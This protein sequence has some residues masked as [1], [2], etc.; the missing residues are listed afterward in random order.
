[1]LKRILSLVLAMLF[2]VACFAGCSN[3]EDDGTPTLVW[4]VPGDAQPRLADVIEE[5][6]KI[7]VEKIGAKV[8]LRFIDTSSY[9][10]RM[11][12]NMAS[13]D[14]YDLCFTGY[15]NKYV[16]AVNNEALYCISDILDKAPALKESIPDYVWEGASVNGKIY[17]V[18]NQQIFAS[19][20]C[21]VMLKEYVDKYGFDISKVT[22]TEDIEPFLEVIKNNEPQ[23]YPYRTNYGLSGFRSMDDKPFWGDVQ[24]FYYAYENE[25]G[26]VTYDKKLSEERALKNSRIL[27][28]WYKKGYIRKDVATVANDN[29]DLL[30]GKYFAWIATYKP[31]VEGE[32]KNSSNYE[33]VTA[34]VQKPKLTNV[35]STM[36]GIGKD[37][38][39]PELALKLIE[40]LNTDKELYNLVCFGIEGVDYNKVGENRI[41]TV[42]N[43]GYNPNASWKF[44]NQFNAYLVEG[45][46]DNVW[47]ETKAL[48]DNSVVSPLI[49]FAL[50][51]SNIVGELTQVQ[52]VMSKYSNISNGTVDPDTCFNECLAELKKAGIDKIISESEKQFNEFLKGR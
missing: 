26:T 13:R 27:H 28:D 46:S 51:K 12:M 1:M 15:I 36:I 35:T 52:T 37:S 42:S 23:L 49:G 19:S 48:N 31:G 47:E 7:T 24:A 2:I 20:I 10:E 9:Q 11:D 33:V 14:P 50:D 18:P 41:E 32:I 39:N 16:D 6:N 45:Q 34:V 17:A 43:S 5:I 25:D 40:L 29:Q 4:Y 22:K 21:V 3:G 8:D 38:K 44:G 30:A